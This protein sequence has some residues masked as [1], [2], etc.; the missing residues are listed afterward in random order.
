MSTHTPGPWIYQSSMCD[1]GETPHAVISAKDLDSAYADGRYLVVRGCIDEADAQLIAAAPDM[2][3]AL[4]AVAATEMYW[5]EHPLRFAAYKAA[6][7]AIA[8]AQ[9]GQQ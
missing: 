6:R 1:D 5:L 9:G 8:K 7:A 4:K 2:L 3:A